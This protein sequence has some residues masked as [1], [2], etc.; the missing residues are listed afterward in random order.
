MNIGDSDK[1]FI[2]V[3]RSYTHTKLKVKALK[4]TCGK[5]HILFSLV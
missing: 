3:G 4:L 5:L 1:D 2:V